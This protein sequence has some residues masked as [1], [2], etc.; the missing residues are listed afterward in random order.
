MKQTI[1]IA[2]KICIKCNT[3]KPIDSYYFHS[4]MKDGRLNKCIQCA[5]I[6]AKRRID[7]MKKCEDWVEAEKKRN[8][9]KYYR[10]NYSDKK[11]SFGVAKKRSNNYK[12]RYP[13]KRSAVE[14]SQYISKPIG[15]HNHHWSYNESHFKDVIQ[16]PIKIHYL[17]HRHLIYDP[18]FKM[19]RR[20]DN[21]ELLDSRE[22]HIK[23]INSLTQENFK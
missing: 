22:S 13:E 5:K 12:L 1:T 21:L 11:T 8:R 2:E 15:F 6:D 17:V 7:K 16:L 4:E 10:L 18:S 14:A 9:D 20:K 23:F 3:M 19:Y